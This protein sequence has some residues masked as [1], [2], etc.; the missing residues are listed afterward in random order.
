MSPNSTRMTNRI[1]ELVDQR[2]S[3]VQATV[4]RAQ[5]PTSA[6]PGD[7]AVILPDGSIEGFVGGQCAET[8]VRTTALEVLGSGEALLLRVLPEDSDEFPDSPGA[9]T[10]V[11]PCLSGGALEI[12]LEPKLPSP[13]LAVVGATPIA[14][15]LAE[16]GPNLGF[17]IQTSVPGE[18]PSN[19]D[20]DSGTS[21][22]KIKTKTAD[23]DGCIAM[24]VASH[25]R[26]ETDA[27]RDALAADVG[28]IGLV[29]STTRGE[30]V[31]EE[32]SLSPDDRKRVH[33]PVGIAIGARTAEEI[34]ISIL[35]DV[36]RAI[37][38]DGLT[39]TVAERPLPKNATDPV[40]GMSV[41]VLADTPH[42][43]HEGEDFWFCNPGCRSRFADDLAG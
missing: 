43:A 15:A 36:I 8:S 40:C 20:S 16:F 24:I 28:F 12:Y 26:G 27:I 5:C 29:A 18:N 10:V 34:A 30:A 4:V 41:T 14:A 13:V 21:T 42:L 17:A 1:T 37:R 19:S 11:N 25:G 31:I 2:R 9:I 22:G 38:V 35:A 32:L 6:R 33:S 23:L 7:S 3:F 39:A